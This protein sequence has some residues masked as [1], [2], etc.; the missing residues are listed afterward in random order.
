VHKSLLFCHIQGQINQ[1]HNYT[2]FFKGLFEDYSSVHAHVSQVVFTCKSCDKNFV[3]FG[4][5]MCIQTF[6]T[7]H[8]LIYSIILKIFGKG[9]CY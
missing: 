9:I 5:L 8:I 6:L 1:I 4:Y 7:H 3:H 2:L